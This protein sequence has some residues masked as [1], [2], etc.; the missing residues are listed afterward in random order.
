MENKSVHVLEWENESAVNIHT[1]VA[2]CRRFNLVMFG[3]ILSSL[4]VN[5][6]SYPMPLKI[7]SMVDKYSLME[8]VSR[9]RI[10]KYLNIRGLLLQI[11]FEP[12]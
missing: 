10:K 9:L 11:L 12:S 6:C 1:A 3:E 8:K 5:M 2:K 4:Q 7:K